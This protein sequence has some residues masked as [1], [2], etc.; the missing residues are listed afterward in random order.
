MLSVDN[1]E[2]D[3]LF[4]IHKI[5]PL[6]GNPSFRFFPA[7][8]RPRASVR[9]LENFKRLHL[10]CKRNRFFGH[11][12]LERDGTRLIP[13]FIIYVM[14]IE[15]SGKKTRTVRDRPGSEKFTW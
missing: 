8:E 1:R 13:F 14:V 3:R 6:K 9:C 2:M 4:I 12:F 11:N 5:D 10:G 7:R 15:T